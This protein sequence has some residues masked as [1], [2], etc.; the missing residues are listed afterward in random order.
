VVLLTIQVFLDVTLSVGQY[1]DDTASYT[2]R[3]ERMGAKNWAQDGGS[4]GEKIKPHRQL[5]ERS[6]IHAEWEV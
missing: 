4:D 3:Q 5:Q 1:F 2:T 6:K